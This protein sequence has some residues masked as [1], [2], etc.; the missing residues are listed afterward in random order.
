MNP[1]LAVNRLREVIRRQHKSLAT[2]S[3]YVYWLRRYIATLR[4]L[5]PQ[6]SSTEKL[7]RFLT[8]LACKHD[9]SASTQNQ[10][11]NAI[12]F[13]YQ[14]VLH[15]QIE[16]VDALRAKR[17]VHARHAPTVQETRA[18]LTTIPD[19]A[20]YP[21][22]LVARILYGWPRLWVLQCATD[23]LSFPHAGFVSGTLFQGQFLIGFALVASASS[24]CCPAMG[25]MK[26]RCFLP[27]RHLPEILVGVIPK[28]PTRTSCHASA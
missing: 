23:R 1:E 20:G 19:S 26:T 17:P 12:V 6:L 5:P 10:A 16:A 11:L 15:Q 24:P 14:D 4:N 28:S 9:V 18:L 22:N 25:E 8:R 21:T 27:R 2:E 13:F 7:E 3:A